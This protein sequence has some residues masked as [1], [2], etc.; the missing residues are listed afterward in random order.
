MSQSPNTTSPM[1]STE[2]PNSSPLN[3]TPITTIHP[4]FASALN[5]KPKK[6]TAKRPSTF[7]T[8]K[9][10]KIKSSSSS[11]SK[12]TSKKK[13]SNS[14]SKSIHTMQE[15]YLDNVAEKN[16]ESHVEASDNLASDLII[17]KEKGNSE[18]GAETLEI[19]KGL[20]VE[21]P[22]ASEVVGEIV[23]DSPDAEETITDQVV[24]DALNSLKGVIPN[25]APDATTSLAKEEPTQDI[26]G[27]EVNVN[28]QV[29]DE[30]VSDR[31]V[32]TAANGE[33]LVSQNEENDIPQVD[34]AP[35]ADNVAA[36]NTTEIPPTDNVMS[37]D[38][39]IVDVDAM[40]DLD[41]TISEVAGGSIARRLRNRKGKDADVVE[42][43]VTKATPSKKKK[44]IGPS[45]K[46]SKVEIASEKKKKSGK[47]KQAEVGDSD[48]EVEEDVPHSV[49]NI[50]SPA[51][52]K[53][54]KK[55]RK[56]VIPELD[57]VHDVPN[58]VSTGK[59]KIGGKIIPQNVPDVPMD[60]ISFHF[61]ESAQKW[62][63]VANRRLAL[64]RELSDEALEQKE[65]IAL[66]EKAGLMKTMSGIG[67]C[68]EKLVK[69][70]LVNIPEDC[71]NPLSKEH[72]KVY[73]RGK[74]VMFSPAIINKVLGNK[75]DGYAE[76]EVTNNHVC[77]TITANQV[78][79][80]PLKGKVPSVMLSVKYAILNRIGTANWVPTTHTSD[81][82]TGL[83]RFIY[84]V[85]TGT[86]FNYGAHIFDETVQHAKSWAI[87]MPIAFPSLICSII[88]TQHP[89]ILTADDEVSKRE[90]P[91]DFHPRLFEGTHAA[92][93]EITDPS[94]AAP[95]G[96]GSMS[97]KEMIASLEAACKALDEK[98]KSLEQ[99]IMA[100]RQEEAAEE[101]ENVQVGQEG[102]GQSDGEGT[103]ELELSDASADF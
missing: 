35:V 32:D 54:Q 92:D 70:F 60:N 98:K 99:V 13:G 55:F 83:A 44:M 75:E 49:S 37:G 102:G 57:V 7:K 59:K 87:R 8:P 89:S 23:Q 29:V 85:G 36:G 5:P 97:R 18:I 95:T 12:K 72:H 58:I 34:E 94:V 17:E 88:L 45:R 46:P 84:S 4:S 66:I 79:V 21:M 15:L 1:K 64:E 38:D 30:Y 43:V 52:K 77:K 103:E 16:V 81:I 41:Q 14:K 65:I 10:K 47:R 63:F 51:K 86:E 82:A 62:K 22:V 96:S 25:V 50:V 61:I 56:A 40:T 71:D 3:A 6:T 31:L 78:K 28:D 67:D 9:S 74:S 19:Q 73:V 93:I 33:N 80:W 91:F 100:L 26:V 53:S 90:S 101:G 20:T 48:Y 42:K 11:V 2:S 76:M 27:G 68:Y 24:E 39:D 69:E